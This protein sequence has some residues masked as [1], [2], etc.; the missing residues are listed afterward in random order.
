MSRR[1][2]LIWKYTTVGLIPVVLVLGALGLRRWLD[3]ET[4]VPDQDEEGITRA[5]DR[6]GAAGDSPLRFVDATEEAAIWFEHF[7]FGRTSQIPEDMGPGAAWGDYDRDGDPDLFLVNFA[8]PVGTPAA[9]LAVSAATDVLYRNE[10]DGTFTD[11]TAQAG[12][13]GAHFGMGAAWG[14]YDAD[15]LLDL[16]VTAWGDPLLWRNRGDGTFEDVTARAGLTGHGFWAGAS[17][18]DFDR[19]GDLDAY[20]VGYVQYQPELGDSGT[21]DADFPF[22]LNPS[23]YPPEPNRLFVN[24]GDG[25][26]VDRAEAAGVRD[27]DGKGMSAAWVD[28]DQ[29]GWLDLYVANDVS[30]NR[31]YRNRGDGTFEDVS[32]Q[33]LV[34]DYRG[35]MGIAVGDWDAD[36]DQDLF[37]THWIA[38]ENALF[39]STLSQLRGSGMEARLNFSDDADRFGLGQVSLDLIGWAT[40]FSDFDGDGWLDLWVANGSTMQ[41]RR[42]RTRLVA[43][44]PHLY[45]N[46]GG[47][48][49]FY[50][51]GEQAGFRSEPTLVGRG[52]AVADYDRDGDLDILVMHVGGPAKLFRNDSEGGHWLAMRLTATSSHPSAIGA[53]V[54]AYTGG[55]ALM[56]EIGAEPSYMSQSDAEVLIGLGDAER[57]DSVVVEWPGGP[58][59]VLHDVV[60]DRRYALV[61]GSE[62]RRLAGR[63]T[64]EQT[65]RFWELDREVAQ[66][67]NAGDWEAAIRGLQELLDLDPDHEDSLYDMGNAFLETGRYDEAVAAWERLLEVN[68]ASSRAWIQLGVVR[69]MPV[70]G[71]LYDL[72][73]AVRAF[74]AAYDLNRE[75]S[76]PLVLWG[77][78]ALALGDRTTAARVLEAGYRMND[79]AA[80]ALFLSGY[81]AWKEGRNERARAL[82][83]SAIEASG[84]IREVEG[85]SGEG[86]TRSERM[87]EVRR[88]AAAR[89]LFSGCVEALR[90]AEPPADPDRLYACVDTELEGLPGR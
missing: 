81:L 37:I 54:V 2:W 42:D 6:T 63:L 33:A 45:W 10:G 48:E 14:D 29:D 1:Q 68:A 64:R 70:A 85:A 5:L 15:G 16:M 73:G 20:V 26:F 22:T 49:G 84:G 82:L 35:A 79:R 17:W 71:E 18:A 57:V 32:Y 25:T 24:Q 46:R 69:A 4:Y 9:D 47:S 75:E 39:S 65:Q 8:G 56:R 50:E 28:L 62:P 67:Y 76:N 43:M 86:D 88:L 12:V 51:V 78:A 60:A 23:S 19:D 30:D 83:E 89:R 38:Q 21:G 13:G 66:A 27:P 74:E 55:R 7:P 90:S 87:A 53:R 77:E 72:E 31:L 3:S 52:G 58:R 80:S 11:V 36:L 44:D 34:A 61:E 41:D 40:S 59:Q